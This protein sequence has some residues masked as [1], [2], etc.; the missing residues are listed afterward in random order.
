MVSLGVV[1]MLISF[2][3]MIIPDGGIKKYSSLAM[4]FMLICS[5]LSFLPTSADEVVFDIK[6]YSVSEKDVAVAEAEY[7]AQVIKKHRENLEKRIKEKMK[8]KGHVSVEVAPDGEIISVNMTVSEDESVA[9]KYIVEDLGVSRER[10]RL[11]Y[12]KN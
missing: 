11:K 1:L 5:A 4:G 9:V 2:S 7:R 10:I 12:D 8:G 3:N 6:S